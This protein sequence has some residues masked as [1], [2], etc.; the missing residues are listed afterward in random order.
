MHELP[1]AQAPQTTVW[2]QLFTFE[3]HVAAPQVTAA[4]SGTQQVPDRQTSSSAAPAAGPAAHVHAVQ[5]AP[6]AQVVAHEAPAVP[7]SKVQP[8]AVCSPHLPAQ[9][10]AGG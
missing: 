6:D 8:S 2:P 7:Q 1:V 9:N 4:V 5:A 10:A 3:P